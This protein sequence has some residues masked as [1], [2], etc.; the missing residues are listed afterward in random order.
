MCAFFLPT[1]CF[2]LCTHIAGTRIG[3]MTRIGLPL[4]GTSVTS[5][6][7]S[8]LLISNDM[9]VPQVT[10]CKCFLPR[11][12]PRGNEFSGD[13]STLQQGHRVTVKLN[14]TGWAELPSGYPRSNDLFGKIRPLT[15]CA[16]VTC[17]TTVGSR[18]C[19][20]TCI[21]SWRAQG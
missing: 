7:Q 6:V 10:T 2:R 4:Y 13:M 18:S 14:S 16:A 15:L 20:V 3:H 21:Q 9:L 17:K 1:V 5:T 12:R 11:T 8:D 19:M